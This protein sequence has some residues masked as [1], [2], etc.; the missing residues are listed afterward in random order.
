MYAGVFPEKVDK[1]VCLDLARPPVTI[2]KMI[3]NRLRKTV[4]KLLKY[5]SAILTGPE[6]PMSYEEALQ[7]NISGSFGSLDKNACDILFKRG[8]KEVDGG[9]VF[10]RDR[11]LM[12]APLTLQPK[13]DML[14]LA[15]EVTADVLFIKFAQGPEFESRE[16]FMEHVETLKTKSRSVRYCEVEGMHHTHLTHPERIAPIISEFF[17][18]SPNS[19]TTPSISATK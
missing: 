16:N 15:K 18:A 4:G 7:R 14:M 6:R 12:A 13:D 8:L 5:E 10:R 2:P 3:A 11:R 9:Y 1:L 17:N 19:T